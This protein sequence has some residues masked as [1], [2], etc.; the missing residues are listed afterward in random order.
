MLTIR[1][2]TRPGLEPVDMSIEAGECVALSGASGAGKSVLMRAIVDLDPNEGEV[3]LDDAARA[4]IPAPRWRR[5]VAYV[6]PDSGWWADDV[7]S[8]FPDGDAAGRLLSRLGLPAE[9]LDWPVARLSTGERQR[10]ALA[11]ALLVE[12]RVLLLDEPT[13][14]L[15]R[16]TALKVED[17]LRERLADGVA[18]LLVTHDPEQTRRLARR[19]LVMKDGRITDAAGVAAENRREAGA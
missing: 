12:P 6:P 15:D 1:H 18:I 13:S 17:T 5:L 16:E 19:R 4:D 11:R 3:H 14:G 7:A 9:A 2:L 10:L 8:H